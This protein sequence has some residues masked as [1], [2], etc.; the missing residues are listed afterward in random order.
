MIGTTR[1]PSTRPLCLCRLL[2]KGNIRY[3]T[4]LR[5]CV[6]LRLTVIVVVVTPMF[7]AK[8]LGLPKQN[9]SGSGTCGRYP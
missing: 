6:M 7:L 5:A 1:R 8:R 3:A 2:P 9:S 4:V